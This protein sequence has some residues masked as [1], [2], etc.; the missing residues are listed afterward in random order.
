MGDQECDEPGI[1][2]LKDPDK[3]ILPSQG[4]IMI[5]PANRSLKNFR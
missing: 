5:F 4:M 3:E 1:L 2:K